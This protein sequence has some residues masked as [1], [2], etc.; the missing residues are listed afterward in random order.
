M[1]NKKVFFRLVSFDVCHICFSTE[2]D[3]LP[4]M[5]ELN[6]FDNPSSDLEPKPEETKEKIKKMIELFIE[7]IVP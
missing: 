6:E 2:I 3:E 1:S 7:L 5:I 4:S